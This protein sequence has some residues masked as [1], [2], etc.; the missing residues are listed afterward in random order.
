M[1][2][3]T[4]LDAQIGFAAEST[5]GTAVTVTRFLE[6]RSESIAFQPTWLEPTGL[7]PGRKH[8][9]VNRVVQSRKAVA[10]DV[11]LEHAT[12]GMGLL[13]AHA[14]GSSGTATQ[15][16]LTTAYQQIHTPGDKL[17][18]SLTVQVGRPQPS[19]GVVKPFTF[20]G[21]KVTGWSFSV[22][23]GEIPS[24]TLNFDGRDE[25]TATALASPSYTAGSAVFNFSQ[26]TLKLGGTATTSSG[27]IG[28]SGNTAVATVIRSV[29]MSGETPLATERFGVGNAGLKSQPLENDTPTVTGTLEAEFSQAELYD[30]FKNQTTTAIVLEFTGATDAITTG[31]TYT[32]R[33]TIPAAKLK[34]AAP[35][36]GGPDIVAMSTGFE[37]YDDETNAP[38]EVYI[39]STDTAI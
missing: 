25:T 19:D 31:H 17:G 20:A 30:V 35:A 22:T 21:M 38:F 6:F 13:W 36:V 37:A 39:K 27:L 14:L 34:S 1:T 11:T 5:Y 26:A 33:L 10:G 9:R 7:R 18:K 8:K 32:L 16:G 29:S 12:K 15:I 28:V 23:D 24:L 4:G 3:G 2:T